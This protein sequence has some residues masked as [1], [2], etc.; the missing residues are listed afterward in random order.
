M[1]STTPTTLT[2]PHSTSGSLKQ[3]WPTALGVAATATSLALVSPLPAQ[4]QMWVSAWGVLT[5]AVI[6]LAWGTARGDLTAHRWLTLETT[7]V[8]AFGALA[9]AAAAADPAAARY[10]LAAGWLG[11]ATW[12]VIHHHAD[13]VVPRWYAELCMACDLLVAASLLLIGNL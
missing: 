4:V 7:G 3:R 13:R 11:H 6:Y 10:V 2:Y 1:I 12:D 5:A 8:L 9:I